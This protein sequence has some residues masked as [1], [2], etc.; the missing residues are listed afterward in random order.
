MV[1]NRF[2]VLHKSTPAEGEI[3]D[4]VSAIDQ[5]LVYI[6]WNI[7]ILTAAVSEDRLKNAASK[8]DTSSVRKCPPF[9]L[10]CSKSLALPGLLLGYI[11]A[12]L[13]Y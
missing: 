4:L 2:Q 11:G 13:R 9:T 8:Q 6:T 3:G 12:C 10:V 1:A 7:A 5:M